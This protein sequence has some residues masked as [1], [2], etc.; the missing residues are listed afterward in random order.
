MTHG[1]VGDRSSPA[2]AHP[3]P[4]P[5]ANT[6]AYRAYAVLAALLGASSLALTVRF[7]GQVL[8]TSTA[9]VTGCVIVLVVVTT[10]I[11]RGVRVP[12]TLVGDLP[13]ALLTTPLLAVAPHWGYVVATVAVGYDNVDVEACRR[14]GVRVTNTPGVLTDAT[15]DLTLALLLGITRR[16]GEGERLL[17]AG[18]P[19]R[20]DLDFL[21]GTGL[22][23]GVP[24]TPLLATPSTA[25]PATYQ[26]P[27]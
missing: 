21:L 14:R 7:P 26:I 18:T 8:P 20:W 4:P 25:V 2:P 11:L 13:E 9:Y 23:I 19:W 16:V 1:A 15:A 3:T 12:G 6:P 27:T 22:R 5:W 24:P 10:L 17:R